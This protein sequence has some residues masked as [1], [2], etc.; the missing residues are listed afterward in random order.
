MT[1]AKANIVARVLQDIDDFE[2]FMDEI[3]QVVNNF[4]GN[5]SAFFEEQL[6]PSMKFEL[7]RRK[8]V[9]EEL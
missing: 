4:D 7:A 6:L 5:V 9:L 2:L 1:R 8:Q 3:E